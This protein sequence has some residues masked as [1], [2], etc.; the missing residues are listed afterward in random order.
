MK[1][2]GHTMGVPDKNIFEAIDFFG[3]LGYEGIEVR[4]ASND[5]PP[6]GQINPEEFDNL[7]AE[8]IVNKLQKKNMEIA[9]LSPYYW[10]YIYPNMREQSIK[11]MKKVVKIAEELNCKRIRAFGGKKPSKEISYEEA[12]DKTA[13]GLQEV[14]KFARDC[15]VDICVST[16]EGFLTQCPK[17]VL[18][19]VKEISLENV[20]ILYD[21]AYVDLCGMEGMENATNMVGPYIKHV[22]LWNYIISNREKNKRYTERQI[23]PTALLRKGEIDIKRLLR[24]LKSVKYQ[25]Y[26]SDEYEKLWIDTF[27][28]AEIGM[29]E[30]INYLKQLLLGI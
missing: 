3:A 7:V 6:I 20:G 4:C 22:H 13:S 19:M 27:P 25:G 5:T 15:G 11:G 1:L 17:E 2:C 12:W 8:K 30:N 29:R 24:A 16:H 28:D 10:N 14:G 18:K 26:L 23:K 21:Y 9:C